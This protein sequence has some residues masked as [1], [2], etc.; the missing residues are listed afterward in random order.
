MAVRRKAPS[1]YQ[2]EPLVTPAHWK[3][4][5]RQLVQRLTQ[6]F[7]QLFARRVSGEQGPAGPQGP[8][9]EKGD[10][11][12]TG[13]IGPAGPQGPQGAV[14]PQGERGPQ[15][16]PGVQP[17]NLLGNSDFTNPVNQRGLTSYHG[18]MTI[19][20][21]GLA[22]Q[23]AAGTLSVVSGG[24][25]LAAANSEGAYTNITQKLDLPQSTNGKPMTYAVMCKEI[26]LIVLSVKY[27]TN[28]M[29]T[30]T[31]GSVALV[32]WSGNTFFIRN[33]LNDTRT[34][35]WAALYEGTYTAETLPPYVP[36]EPV[37]ELLTCQQYALVLG[38]TIRYRASQITTSVIDFIIPTPVKMRTTPSFAASALTVY[39]TS[40]VMT[41]V[42]AQNGFTFSILQVGNN[43]ICIRA[44]KSG[45]G[46]VDAFLSIAE[47]TVFS[48]DL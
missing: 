36:K 26:G 18:G 14:G 44:T 41:S 38:G 27:G 46:L 20:R 16:P 35:E 34:F 24:I 4:E 45:H 7:D 39:G 37:T 9:G 40:G 28:A 29:V 19:D 30:S 5:E 1:V 15:G 47:N 31:D 17:R 13:P 32:H 21:W 48:A 23:V 3:G 33:Y 22:S 6:L 43:A 25:T 10:T 8:R 11:G 2:Y 42:S 12:E